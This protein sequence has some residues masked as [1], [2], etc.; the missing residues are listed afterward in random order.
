MFVNK[1][2]MIEC[3][4]EIVRL[5]SSLSVTD[6]QI[7]VDAHKRGWKVERRGRLVN[8]QVYV[9]NTDFLALNIVWGE[10]VYLF[11]NFIIFLKLLKEYIPH[12]LPQSVS[13]YTG[14]FVI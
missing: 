7:D 1:G 4:W 14:I 6:G 8:S 9:D 13:V 11:I 10:L 2:L 5:S 3:T 12:S